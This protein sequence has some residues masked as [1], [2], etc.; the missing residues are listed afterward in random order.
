MLVILHACFRLLGF[1]N[2]IQITD[3]HIASLGGLANEIDTRS[4]FERILNRVAQEESPDHIVISGDI[5]FKDPDITVYNYIKSLLDK[6][7]HNYHIISGN[8]DN[9]SMISVIFGKSKVEEYYYKSDGIIFLDTGKG[10]MS[11]TQWLWFEKVLETADLREIIIFM[12][13]PP[14]LAMV[15]HMDQKY[16]FMEIER[17]QKLTS[18]YNELEFFIFSGHYHV[19]RSLKLRNMNVYI[20]PSCFIQISDKDVEFKADHYYPAYRRIVFDKETFMTTVRYLF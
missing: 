17:F 8:H 18:R 3:L 2:I 16:T 7:D 13:H 14:I 1:M 11:E 4:N 15:P 20:T 5:C 12:H 9:S 6:I 19:E 10:F